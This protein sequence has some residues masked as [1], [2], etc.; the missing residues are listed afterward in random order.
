MRLCEA[1][2]K[3]NIYFITKIIYF[4]YTTKFVIARSE[5]TK[6]SSM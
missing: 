5:M 4:Q 1:S 6:Q 2:V 3:I